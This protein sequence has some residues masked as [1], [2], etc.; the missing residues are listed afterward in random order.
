MGNKHSNDQAKNAFNP[1]TIKRTFQPVENAFK[2]VEKAFTKE[3][4]VDFGQRVGKS[5]GEVGSVLGQLGGVADKVL[6]NPITGLIVAS[7]PE[8]LPFYL[9]AKAGTGVF[10]GTGAGLQQIGTAINK[11]D[12]NVRFL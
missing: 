4:I 3:N 7:N 8:L 5:T 2:P 10:R 11:K 1:A 12:N 9:G 6:D